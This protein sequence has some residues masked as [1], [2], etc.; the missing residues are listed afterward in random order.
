MGIPELTEGDFPG[1]FQAADENAKTS[2]FV[3]FLLL[4]IYLATL[5]TGSILQELFELDHPKFVSF[6]IFLV[7]SS[8][9]CALYFLRYDEKWY[10]GRA[11]AESVKTRTWRWMMSSDP[12]NGVSEDL[13][14]EFIED[15][16]EI[17]IN[18]KE[19][20]VIE[21]TRHCDKPMIS[22][23]MKEIRQLELNEKI[24]IYRNQRIR[25]QLLYYQ[26]AGKKHRNLARF[27]FFIAALINIIAILSVNSPENWII[28]NAVPISVLSTLA[29]CTFTWL[30]AKRY[31]ELSIS[32]SFTA[33]EIGI[34]HS[35]I[36]SIKT[37]EE[38]SNFVVSTESAFS[39]EHTHWA[40][41]KLN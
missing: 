25:D 21:N 18:D 17:L 1:A 3:H 2:Q 40:A 8:S 24:N 20:A 36:L 19:K 23:K 26:R 12:Y 34:A 28:N 31:R 10:Y 32:Y 22:E 33:Q 41:R 15:V 39:R 38:F 5:I 4:A 29:G 7:S 6:F 37:P 27:W 35:K 16:S 13:D 14:Y 9:L 30:Q 11:A